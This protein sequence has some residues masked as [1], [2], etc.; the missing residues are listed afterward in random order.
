MPNGIPTQVYI[1]LKNKFNSLNFEVI[2]HKSGSLKLAP[3]ANN[4]HPID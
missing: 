4:P 2:N 1:Y 3:V